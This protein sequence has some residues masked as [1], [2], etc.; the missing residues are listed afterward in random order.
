MNEKLRTVCARLGALTGLEPATLRHC[1]RVRTLSLVIGENL[2]L[3]SSELTTLSLGSLLHDIG[4]KQI[5]RDIL[6]KST[7]LT[8]EEWKTIQQHPVDG[9]EYARRHTLPHSVQEIILHHHLWYDGSGGYPEHDD[10]ARPSCLTQIASVADVVDA[11]TQDRPYRRALGL[12]SSLDFLAEQSGTQ[13]SPVVVESVERNL[14]Q[15][16]KLVGA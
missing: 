6:L 9:Y 3:S 12:D 2:G 13:F 8:E 15:I 5:P 16:K 14:N 1:Q 11:M 4:K 7:P 10:D